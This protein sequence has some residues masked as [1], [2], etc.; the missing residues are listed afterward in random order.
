MLS[1]E[2]WMEAGSYLRLLPPVPANETVHANIHPFNKNI[3]PLNFDI[4]RVN[5]IIESFDVEI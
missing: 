4:E 5:K 3:E 1:S 2:N